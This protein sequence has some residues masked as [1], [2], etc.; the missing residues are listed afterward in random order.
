MRRVCPALRQSGDGQWLCSV[1]ARDVRPFWGRAAAHGFGFMAI[2]YL[3]TTLTV[4]G[5][6]R[7]IG[8]PLSYASV[9]W[10]PAWFRIQESRAE[11][12]FGKAEHAF[13]TSEVRE[14]L[15]Y[16]EQSYNL[17]PTNYMAGRVLAL[18]AASISPEYSE[19]LY[20]R[21]E[22]AHPEQRTATAQAWLTLL[23]IQGDSAKIENLAKA[24]MV[25][26]A[27]EAPGWLNAF[28]FAN[29]RTHDVEILQQLAADPQLSPALRR[30]LGWEL[31][32]RNGDR[33]Q[34]S[35]L[36]TQP[37]GARE[38]TPPYLVFYRINRLLETGLTSEALA[39]LN[40]D[41]ALLNADDRSRLALA[42]YQK[43]GWQSILDDQVDRALAGPIG[44]PFVALLSAHL[45][46]HPD[47]NLLAKVCLALERHPLTGAADASPAYASLF[48]AAGAA[49]DWEQLHKIASRLE[50]IAGRSYPALGFMEAYFRN[51]QDQPP[52]NKLLPILAVLP[53]E[54]DYAMFEFS[55]QRRSTTTRIQQK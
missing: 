6:L 1:D 52:L 54:V 49:G 5:F 43:L 10:P 50:A 40:R 13:K 27:A 20:R 39:A 32:L 51:N 12:F 22:F 24:Q 31:V 19:R 18:A 16:L 44:A 33:A 2:S 28:L 4:F 47:R 41:R 37:L 23:L 15:M 21:L 38:V 53:V 35:R 8:Y 11:Y 29:R 36:L 26:A 55:E 42:V 25:A 17:D 48:C 45:I 46:R 34:A 30:I 9:V 3:A 14:G 7:V